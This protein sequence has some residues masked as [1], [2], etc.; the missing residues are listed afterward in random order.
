MATK[1]VVNTAVSNM[2]GAYTDRVQY[3]KS[4][5]MADIGNHELGKGSRLVNKYIKAPGIRLRQYATWA[6][7]QKH[8]QL[9]NKTWAEYIGLMLPT[10]VLQSQIPANDLKT[11]LVSIVGNDLNIVKSKYGTVT[12][13]DIVESYIYEN[14]P[15]LVSDN[16]DWEIQDFDPDADTSIRVVTEEDW[17]FYVPLSTLPVG[18]DWDKEYLWVIYKNTFDS[19]YRWFNSPTQTSRNSDPH[20]GVDFSTWNLDSDT[21]VT[22]ITRPKT[23]GTEVTISYTGPEPFEYYNNVVTANDSIGNDR[24]REYSRVRSHPVTGNSI[25]ETGTHT[26]SSHFGYTVSES[27]ATESY[28]SSNGKTETKTTITTTYTPYTIRTSTKIN[29]R[30]LLGS[31]I[32]NS[33]KSFFYEY[34]AGNLNLDDIIDGVTVT[35]YTFTT[36]IPFIPFISNGMFLYLTDPMGYEVAKK[37]MERAVGVDYDQFLQDVVAG[38][39][40]ADLDFLS[41][42]FAVP[43]NAKRDESKKYLFEFF[44]LLVTNSYFPQEDLD[45]ESK[46]IFFNTSGGNFQQGATNPLYYNFKTTMSWNAGSYATLTNPALFPPKVAAIPIGRADVYADMSGVVY[47][48]YKKTETY[49][50]IVALNDLTYLNHVTSGKSYGYYGGGELSPMVTEDSGFLI[51]LIP[52]ILTR[53]GLVNATQVASESMILVANYYKKYKVSWSRKHLKYL[54]V[55]GGV[56]AGGLGGIMMQSLNVIISTAGNIIQILGN[57]AFV[58]GTFINVV[59]GLTWILRPIFGEFA[60]TVANIIVSTALIIFTGGMAGGFLEAFQSLFTLTAENLLLG[61]T[62][63]IDVYSQIRQRS[64]AKKLGKIQEKSEAAEQEK[65]MWEALDLEATL[66]AGV[67]GDATFDFSQAIKAKD[68]H[69][70]N[71]TL[72]TETPGNFLT[73]TTF[74]G[75]DIIQATQEVIDKLVEIT[76]HTRLS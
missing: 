68:Y 63:V 37:A 36:S 45:D 26:I 21:T 41:L 6:N 18:F 66:E 31:N 56:L 24:I 53:N 19:N 52:E 33:Y 29:Y 12:P 5:I 44:K 35:K 10:F 22:G 74:T 2:A 64:D 72:A 20:R 43:I 13:E 60:R 71:E 4:F 9:G 75:S 17:F 69:E 59:D 42:M 57:I 38:Q 58:G 54:L 61:L 62:A 16:I 11:E 15:Y 47:A 32:G 1:Y 25:T 39:G 3:L 73:R 40:I 67:L 65:E 50:Q 14:Y 70:F 49:C 48:A 76:I 55:V 23:S 8:F 46:S 34:G 51:P 7:S 30:L 28:T 27:T